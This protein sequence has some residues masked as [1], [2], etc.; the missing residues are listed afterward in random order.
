MVIV[1]DVCNN[2]CV[3]QNCLVNVGIE[4]NCIGFVLKTTRQIIQRKQK[5]KY[6]A[7]VQV[8]E[9]CRIMVRAAFI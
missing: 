4:T 5:L 6:L 7:A 2:C 3:V 1:I 8:L 9:H